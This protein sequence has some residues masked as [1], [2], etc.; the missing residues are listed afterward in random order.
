VRDEHPNGPRYGLVPPLA[1]LCLTTRFPNA[2]NPHVTSVVVSHRA[3]AA[4][5]AARLT[6]QC[7]VGPR[8]QVHRSGRNVGGRSG[9]G[10]AP[11]AGDAL[12]QPRWC[13]SVS[14]NTVLGRCAGG[15]E[16]SRRAGL[17]R[18]P[19]VLPPHEGPRYRCGVLASVRGRR[20]S[21][22]LL[23]LRRASRRALPLRQSQSSRASMWEAKRIFSARR[24]SCSTDAERTRS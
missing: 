22:R 17:P 8:T 23:P 9:F 20:W 14:P 2:S 21:V 15:G 19:G 10:D 13:A 5:P 24:S 4:C 18:V 11:T 3:C 1:R 16:G 7:L 6:I 12:T